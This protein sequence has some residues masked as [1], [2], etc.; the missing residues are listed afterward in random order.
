MAIVVR[1][2]GSDD[3]G[4]IIEG[5]LTAADAKQTDAPALATRWRALA[6]DIGDALDQLPQTPH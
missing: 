1:L 4:E 6:H 3:L 2:T 5:L